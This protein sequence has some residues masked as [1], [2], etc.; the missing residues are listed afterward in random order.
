MED[1]FKVHV[2]EVDEVEIQP[3]ETAL[4][5]AAYRLWR[6]AMRTGTWDPAGVDLSE[7]KKQYEDLGES[8]RV[9]LE[10]FCGAF[11]NAEENVAVLFCPW[12]MASGSLWQEA[13]LGTQLVE[14]YKHTDFFKRY[15]DEVLGPEKRPRALANPVH[16]TLEERGKRLL[17]ALNGPKEERTMRFVEAVTHYQGIIEG[18]QANT[19]YQIFLDVFAR[20]GL[21]PGLSEGFRQIQRDEGRHVSFGLQVLR[22]YAHKD[23]RYARRIREMY[24]EYLP[25]IRRRYGQKIKVDGRE[26]DTPE[27]ERG[28]ERL[29]ALYERRMRDIFG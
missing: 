17:V 18:V 29:M 8:Q 2:E 13:F 4:D 27:E 6:K 25:F 12:I 26:Y 14:E 19:G 11:Y 21:L 24:E 10:A 5:E 9:Y 7:D 15:F 23:D 20:K 22:H 16:D 3:A 1:R 28:L